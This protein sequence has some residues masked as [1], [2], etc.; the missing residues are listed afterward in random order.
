MSSEIERLILDK[1]ASTIQGTES[2][3]P[4]EIRVQGND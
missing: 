4:F 1:I 2:R 3:C